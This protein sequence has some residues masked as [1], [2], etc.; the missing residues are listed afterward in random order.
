[1]RQYS[2]VRA[3]SW[4][5]LMGA[6]SL[7]SVS[8]VAKVAAAQTQP[9]AEEPRKIQLA[10]P[11]P[12]SAEAR[13]AGA[14][15]EDRR[16]EEREKEVAP[17]SG[18][19]GHLDLGVGYGFIMG[20]KLGP[21]P[22]FRPIDDL[23]FS[24][25]VLGVSTQLGGGA[26]DFSIAGE[27]SY[28]VMLSEKEEPDNV[29]FQMFGIGLA[30]NYYTDDDYLI[31]AQ[32]RY[33]GMILWRESLPCFCDR[34]LGTSGPGVGLTLGKEW[35]DRRHRADDDRVHRDKGGHGLALQGNYAAFGTDPNFKYLSIMLQYSMTAF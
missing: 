2:R 20:G 9:T 8:L 19:F 5:S 22:G 15:G 29:G 33:L 31:G 6:V 25:P 28:E 35:Y 4:M 16:K 23:S 30:A 21:E 34:A 27:L 13:S 7:L 32:L 18:F 24:G 14:D 10:E 17:H 3:G 12:A 11:T 26:E 1:M